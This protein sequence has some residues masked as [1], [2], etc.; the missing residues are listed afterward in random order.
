MT[1][2]HG[3][4]YSRRSSSSVAYGSGAPG[5][6]LV[7][8]KVASTR[9]CTNAPLGTPLRE[10]PSVNGPLHGAVLRLE[11]APGGGLRVRVRF[12]AAAAPVAEDAP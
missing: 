4:P 2:G 7:S 10:A 11:D 1:Q 12:P 8:S 3:E 5:V 9:Y 6:V